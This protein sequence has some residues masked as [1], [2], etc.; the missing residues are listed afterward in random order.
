MG[1]C[2]AAELSGGEGTPLGV[3]HTAGY[4]AAQQQAEKNTVE[5]ASLFLQCSF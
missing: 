2:H 4:C 3:L 5:R 1:K